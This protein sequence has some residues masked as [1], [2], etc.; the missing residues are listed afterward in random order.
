ML[1]TYMKL[2]ITELDFQE[3][4]FLPKKIGKWAK[5]GPKTVFFEDIEKFCH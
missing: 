5:N 1:E 4:K 3:K 2:C